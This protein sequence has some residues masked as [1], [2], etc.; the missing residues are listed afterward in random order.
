[1]SKLY[2]LALIPLFY[3]ATCYYLSGQLL[4]PLRRKI[5]EFPSSY[6]LTFEDISFQTAD[7]LNLKGW[8]I[9]GKSE[10][11][12]IITHPMNFNR[13]GFPLKGQGLFKLTN[14]DIK[15]LTLAKNLNK[16][17]YSVLMFDFRNHG[18]S[19]KSSNNGIVGLG[20]NEYKDV[21]AALKYI[22]SREDTKNNLVSFISLC[23]GANSTII[24]DSHAKE[25]FVNV[26]CIIAVQPISFDIFCRSY[27]KDKMTSLSLC[28]L[29]LVNKI[30]QWRGGYP[31]EEMSPRN[32]VGNLSVPIYYFQ[33]KS[34]PWTKLSDIEGFY[35]ASPELKKLTLI[36]GN[37]SRFDTYNYIG[38]NPKIVLDILDKHMNRILCKY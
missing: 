36:D 35:A 12:I 10:N 29:P 38:E 15:L 32:F 25:D 27:L 33:A 19:D 11:T 20:L 21:L 7:N 9:P 30:C 1:M 6:D 18:E 17:G 37:L 24:A 5:S 31:L 26:K 22:K 16:E 4:F 13:H 28:L 14:K 8:F 2:F 34:D 3:V 23:Q